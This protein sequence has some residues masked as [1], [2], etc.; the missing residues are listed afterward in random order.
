[1][2][3]RGEVALAFSQATEIIDRPGVQLA[4]LLPDE[5]QLW[6]VYR[7]AIVQDG[8]EARALLA[9][10]GTDAARTAFGRIGFR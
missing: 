2:I 3:S 7:A 8:A 10:F 9:L 1:M 4:G 6:T 5:I